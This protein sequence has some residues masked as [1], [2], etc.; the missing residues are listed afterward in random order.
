MQKPVQGCKGSEQIQ[1]IPCHGVH[2]DF[3]NVFLAGVS[4][5]VRGVTALSV[6][7][8]HLHPLCGSAF[9]ALQ[10]CLDLVAYGCT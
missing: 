3:R 4:A 9:R 7:T 2:G 10:A 6:N 1:G 5:P 8:G